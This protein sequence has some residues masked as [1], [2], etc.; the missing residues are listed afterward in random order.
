ME[1][2]NKLRLEID[3]INLQLGRLLIERKKVVE[4][5]GQEKHTLGIEVYDRNRETYIFQMLRQHFTQ[6]EY[7]YLE[8]IFKEVIKK[9]RQ[10]QIVSN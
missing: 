6:Q 4:C 2:I 8:P 1:S 5:I 10:V 3:E 7:N 9:S